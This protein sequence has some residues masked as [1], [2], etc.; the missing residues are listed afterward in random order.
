M[1]TRFSAAVVLLVALLPTAATAS[2]LDRLNVPRALHVVSYYPVDAGWT[3]MWTHW[4]PARVA[5]DLDRAVALH[6]NTV[7]AIVQP[8][9]FGYPHVSPL[10]ASRLAQF[11]DLA[12]ARGLHVQLTLFD[13]WYSWFDRRGSQTWARELLAPYAHDPR[14]AFVELRNE[15][16]PKPETIRWAARMIPFVHRL[17]PG[18]PVTLSV[19]GPAVL[20]KLARLKRGLGDV[21]PD[22]YDLHYFGR[23][24]ANAYSTFARA[25]AIVAPTPLWVGETGYPTTTTGSGFGGLPRTRA[26]QESGQ[27]QF[28]ATV[29]WAA[30]ANGL[31]PIGV[32]QLDDLV[33][34]AVPD[35]TV[36][37]EDPDLHYGLFRVDG[38][39]KPAADVV[40]STFDG[41]P[42][43]GFDNGFEEAVGS[44]PARWEMSGD[45]MWFAVDRSVAEEG[46]ASGEIA[47]AGTASYSIV[48]PNGGVRRGDAVSVSTWARRSTA[49]G[50]VALVLEWHD[51]ADRLLARAESPPLTQVA[52]WAQLRLEARAPR[53]AAYVRIDLV[54][55]RIDGNVWF[56]DVRFVRNGFSRP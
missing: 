1:G 36:G 38:S 45:A 3:S 41:S 28:L 4:D 47:G 53:R 25:K 13:W 20:A 46:T 19:A 22:F 30:E 11:V 26:A 31:P 39:A 50:T 27:A 17:L 14:I 24:G 9:T 7:R 5:A 16:L 42:P 33:P 44:V 18:T 43:V 2:R 52:A 29:A 56:D 6:A 51:A 12:A 34:A 21:R 15:I 8:D 55:R 40:R 49:A 32:W 10:Y 23:G 54:A 35:R 48:P 37:A